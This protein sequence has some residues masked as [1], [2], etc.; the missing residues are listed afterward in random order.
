MNN[1]NGRSRAMGAM[2]LAMFIAVF[3]QLNVIQVARSDELANDPRN[4]R[5]IEASFNEPRGSIVTIDGVV[6]ANSVPSE[7]RYTTQR[8]Y[9]QGSLYGHITGYVSIVY[10]TAGAEQSFNDLLSAQT[11]SADTLGSL[12]A[13]RT[14]VGD[15]TLTIDSR[16]QQVAAEQ[17]AGRRGSVVALN[18]QTGAILA[19]Y[20]NPTFDPNT[21]GSQDQT[22]VRAAWAALNDDPLNPL[23]ARSF[24][25]VYSPGSTFKVVTAAAAYEQRPDLVDK[26]YPQLSVLD[27]PNTSSDLPNFGGSTCGGSLTELLRVSCN[28]GFGQMGIDL[29]PQALVTQSELFGFNSEPPIDLPSAAS[30]AFSPVSA[31]DQDIPALAQSAIG[32][33]DVR[34]TP[35]QMALIAAGIANNGVIM[36]PHVLAEARDTTGALL[37]QYAPS[38]WRTAM[39]TANSGALTN[40]MIGVVVRGTATRAAIP[41]VTVAAK[42]GTAQTFGNSANAWLI[43]FAPAENPTVAIAVIIEDQEGLGDITGGR[44]AAPVAKAV[45]EAALSAQSIP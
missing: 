7:G 22:A 32:Q 11:T 44:Y 16:V 38:A 1:M 27:L 34:A 37:R 12:F 10:G 39:S 30:S 26:A 21:L 15:V 9:P 33:R 8:V 18:P 14:L 40:D 5:Q 19:M 6:I 41:G 17:L 28:T 43:S 35:L 23:L 13:D 42:T 24:R 45:M 31:F 36:K 3:V 20:S 29:G 25:E 2:V 4:P